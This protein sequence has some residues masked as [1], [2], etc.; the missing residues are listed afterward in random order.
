MPGAPGH[1]GYGI[2]RLVTN[3]LAQGCAFSPRLTQAA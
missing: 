1:A 3:A 2:A